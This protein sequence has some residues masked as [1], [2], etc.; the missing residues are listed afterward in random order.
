L[1][2]PVITQTLSG[3]IFLFPE[4]NIKLE[5]T[6]V[7]LHKDRRITG[8]L[9]VDA[10]GIGEA[11][12]LHEAEFNFKSDLVRKRWEKDLSEQYPADWKSILAVVCHEVKQ[13]MTQGEPVEFLDNE[14]EAEPISYLIAPLIPLGHPTVL[15]GEG[16]AGKGVLCLGIA[17]VAILPWY[18]NPLGLIAPFEPTRLLYLDWELGNK[19]TKGRLQL[20]KRGMGLPY[21]G[22]EYRRC[23]MPMVDDLESIQKIV[24]DNGINFVIV[25][26]LGMASGGDLNATEPAFR[27]YSALRKLNL[28]SLIIAHTQ[29]G[30]GTKSIYGNVHFF[31][32]ARQVW[33]LKKSQDEGASDINLILY[34]EKH[35]F[36][37]KHPPIG[38]NI[39]FQDTRIVIKRVEAM[40]DLD[41]LTL[42]GGIY[43]LIKDSPMTVKE[44]AEILEAKPASVAI[45]LN[46][47]K[48]AN[49]VVSLPDS[50][51]GLLSRE[52]N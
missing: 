40:E 25:D 15:Y 18:D 52:E 45:T 3:F 11:S 23:S 48:K 16:N 21:L 20:L 6:E 50:K 41:R 37:R 43:S 13:R 35:N 4:E 17:M 19:D 29:K 44:L 8:F 49:Q 47:M 32:Y 38:Y 7:H 33:Q 39:D 24:S 9:K 28:T 46:R 51:W 1:S 36:C 10:L 5:A 31:N 22:M 26:S 14:G 12:H 34:H 2:K 42:K 27:F 30:D